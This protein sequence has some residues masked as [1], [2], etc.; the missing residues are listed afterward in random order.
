MK[1]RSHAHNSVFIFSLLLVCWSVYSFFSWQMKPLPQKIPGS[2]VAEIKKNGFPGEPV[3]LSS[4]LLD[5][6]VLNHSDLNIFPAGGETLKNAKTMSG[7]YII[8]AFKGLNCTDISEK[9]EEKRVLSDGEYVLKECLDSY[10]GERSFN[11]S[12]F[13]SS[14]KVTV[15]PA[16]KPAEFKRGS[17]K[18][19]HNGW[20]KIETGSAEFSGKSIF[21]ISAHPLPEGHEIRIEIPPVDREVSKI[22]AGLGIADSGKTKGSKPVDLKISQAGREIV[23]HSVDGKW[24]EQELKGFSPYELFNITVSTENSSKRHFYFDIKYVFGDGE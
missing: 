13:I 2:I 24:L 19:G 7:F 14:F 18:T 22:F 11:A 12:S 23:F 4:Q 10:A 20:Q 17:F 9:F 6:F 1:N 16:E 8:E 15:P 5:S 21:A 3:F